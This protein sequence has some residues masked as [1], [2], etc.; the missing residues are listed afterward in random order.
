MAVDL[1]H[2]RLG[3]QVRCAPAA[4]KTGI[5]ALKQAGFT[6]PGTKKYGSGL[7][8]PDQRAAHEGQ[9]TRA[10]AR[11]PANAYWAYYHAA[12]G[13]TAWTLQHRR[14]G[15]VPP[16]C[17]AASRAGRSVLAPAPRSPSR[18]AGTGRAATA[19]Q[20]GAGRARRTA[21]RGGRAAATVPPV[22][23]RRR[24]VPGRLAGRR[25]VYDYFGAP[26]Y[27]LTADA[28]LALDAIGS[29]QA[30]ASAATTALAQHVADYAGWRRRRERR[31]GG[32]APRSSRSPRA[33]DPTAFG[34]DDLVATLTALQ[35]PAGR[36]PDRSSSGADSSNTVRA[37]PRGGR[38]HPRHGCGRRR[39]RPPTCCASSAARP[40]RPASGR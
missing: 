34:G 18:S 26:D 33:H 1:T 38:S 39:R 29:G 9:G 4:P 7:R 20:V 6:V 17:R 37:E 21:G 2:V 8:L 3:F 15:L 19:P 16:G 25:G 11:P 30:A 23:R 5:D 31:R 28:V 24:R 14:R 10:S 22:G 35:T 32:Q 13:A 36:Y 27:G 40:G 12:P